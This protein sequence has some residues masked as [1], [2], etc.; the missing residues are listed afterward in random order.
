MSNDLS[1]VALVIPVHNRAT[2]LRRVLAALHPLSA[3][4]AAIVVVDDASMDG[5]SGVATSFGA[6]VVRREHATGPAAARNAGLAPGDHADC[7]VLRQ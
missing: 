6:T 3:R 5:T 4:G 2:A 7:R 1:K